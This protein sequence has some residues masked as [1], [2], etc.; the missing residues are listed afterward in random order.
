MDS[1]GNS[2]GRGRNFGKCG[3]SGRGGTSLNMFLGN[4]GGILG[5]GAPE[6]VSFIYLCVFEFLFGTLCCLC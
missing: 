5:V 6:V 4:D 2:G 3:A 1:G